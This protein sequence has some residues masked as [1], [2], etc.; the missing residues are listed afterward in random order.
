MLWFV[1]GS[2]GE[3]HLWTQSRSWFSEMMD[4]ARWPMS[5][6]LGDDERSI[7]FMTCFVSLPSVKF[8]VKHIRIV[9]R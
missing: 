9:W 1:D 3:S 5:T 6:R 7:R 2:G 8:K 4:K